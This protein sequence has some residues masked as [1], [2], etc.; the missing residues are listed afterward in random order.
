MATRTSMNNTATATDEATPAKQRA[1][2]EDSDGGPRS[3]TRTLRILELVA[4]SNGMLTL[5]QLSQRL[6]I[7]KTSSFS[8]LRPLVAQ[9]YL[10][11]K[12]GRYSL[13]PGTYRLTFLANRSSFFRSVR[14][15]LEKLSQATGETVSLSMVN[16]SDQVLEYMDV[17][18]STRAVRYVVKAGERRPLYSVS[19]GLVLLAWQDP[20][21]VESYLDST[22]LN[23]FTAS[24]VIDRAAIIE[25]LAVIRQTGHV[26][27]VGEYSDDVFGFAAP[28]FSD[29]TKVIAAL[30]IGA[31]ASRAFQNKE[32]YV[33]A[34]RDAA[35]TLSRMF[36]ATEL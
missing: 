20:S 36:S 29:E 14:P 31:P 21:V 6:A 8:L 17:V 12:D 15:V 26:I 33:S 35:A 5:A 16:L 24:T 28:V 11:Y 27:A 1:V 30:S 4:E 7:P 34:L 32:S 9:N 3:P 25:R 2:A 23:R 19:A 13:G 22:Q 10:V 18:E